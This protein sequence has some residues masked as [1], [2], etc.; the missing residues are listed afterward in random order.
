MKMTIY[1]KHY[2]H[3]PTADETKRYIHYGLSGIYVDNLQLTMSGIACSG[4]SFCPASFNGTRKNANFAEQQMYFLDIDNDISGNLITPEQV[5]EQCKDLSFP[6][7]VMYHSFSS[8]PKAPR[9]RVGFKMDQPI[10]D[11]NASQALQRLTMAIF[12]K[13]IDKSC[14]D[15]AR[16]FY[17]SNKGILH[18]DAAATVSTEDIIKH[19]TPY[20]GIIETKDVVDKNGGKLPDSIIYCKIRENVAKFEMQHNELLAEISNCRLLN[21][22]PQIWLY[23]NGYTEN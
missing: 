7:F 12:G 16:L 18:Y 1:S 9:F 2:D 3:K 14:K 11:Y 13:K 8:I 6:P 21:E 22:L 17:G 23:H 10:A 15:P 20:L 19:G 4:W 5:L